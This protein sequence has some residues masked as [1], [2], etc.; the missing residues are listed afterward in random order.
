[1]FLKSEKGNMRVRREDENFFE[2][3]FS[4]CQASAEAFTFTTMSRIAKP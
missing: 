4:G 1:M 3:T 2:F